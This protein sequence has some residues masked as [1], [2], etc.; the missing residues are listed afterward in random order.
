MSA[1]PEPPNDP[2]RLLI[3]G[4]S[5]VGDM[6]MAQSL[7]IV[8][9][10]QYPELVIDVLAPAWSG[11]L[12]DRMPEVNQSIDMPLG[13]GSFG[14]AKRYQ[15][16]QTLALENYDWSILL[17]N[18]LKSA[19]IPFFA[20]IKK[21]SGFIGEMRYGLLNDWHKLDKKR[22]TR[23]VQRFVAL[24]YSNATMY[25]EQYTGMKN[26]PF[27][28]LQINKES[29]WNIAQEKFSLTTQTQQNFPILSLCPGAE[30]G[31]AKQ[32]PAR[33]FAEIAARFWKQ[34]QALNG[35]VWLFGSEK[36]QAFCQQIAQHT[37]IPIKDL[38]GQTSL[39]E[40][41]DLMSLSSAVISN[42]SGLMHVA[43]A[44]GVPILGLYGSS[45]PHFTPPLSQ[46]S[47]VV[48]LGLDC[49]PCFKRTCPLGHLN[50]LE[51]M[52]PDLIWDKLQVLLQA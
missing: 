5:W 42:D 29:A 20:K 30:Y 39:A 15:I 9:K 36:D 47:E 2:R 33:Y 26:I 17:P 22:L 8:L 14:L 41:I 25:Q 31:P 44:V 28:Q 4:P 7:F 32:W 38:S 48:S 27:P 35:Q 19:L 10:H 23:T 46:Y 18:S 50:C 11:A 37:D 40:A 52:T 49:S 21:R 45:D 1:I 24:A 34:N 6:I 13:H 16:G 12:L 3:V 51:K 43:A